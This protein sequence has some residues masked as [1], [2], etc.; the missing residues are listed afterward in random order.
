MRDG[1]VMTTSGALFPFFLPLLSSSSDCSTSIAAAPDIVCPSC[2][3]RLCNSGED[4]R[5][6][7]ERARPNSTAAVAVVDVEVL[8]A[9]VLRFGGQ[10]SEERLLRDGITADYGNFAKGSGCHFVFWWELVRPCVS[11][12]GRP[13]LIF[14]FSSSCIGWVKL[15]SRISKT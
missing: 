15:L 5:G 1:K 6:D 10:E 8:L 11:L 3:S 4:A 7:V 9:E 2:A 12:Q 13:L 14:F